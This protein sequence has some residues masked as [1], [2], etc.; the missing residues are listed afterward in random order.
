ML[1]IRPAELTLVSESGSKEYDG[2]PLER[3]QVKVEGSIITTNDRAQISNIKATGSATG[4]TTDPVPNTI[5]YETSEDFIPENYLIKKT[6]GTLT[7]TKNTKTEIVFTADS[8]QKKYDGTPLTASGVTV[9]GLSN[10]FTAQ[11]EAGGSITNV[12]QTEEGNN[13]VVSARI[14]DKEGKDVTGWFT[15]ITKNAGTLTITAREITLTSADATKVYDGTPLEKK[16][17]TVGGTD[18]LVKTHQ[19]EYTF[20][21]SQTYV[22]SS[23]NTFTYLIKDKEGNVIPTS[24]T[25]VSRKSLLRKSGQVEPEGNYRIKVVYGTLTV[26]DDVEPEKVVTKTHEEKV[27]QLGEQIVF[28]IRVTNIYD[29]A[30]TVTLTEQDGVVFTGPDTFTDVQPGATV[31]TSACH[32]VNEDDLKEGTYTNTVKAEFKEVKKTWEGTDEEDQF[33][34]LTLAK[35]VT[36]APADETAYMNGETIRYQITV[37]NDGTA[38]LYSLKIADILTGDEWNNIQS[39]D[40][41]EELTF[42]T[43]YKVTDH[44]AENGFV[45]NQAVGNA[46]D[47][48]GNF[49]EPQPVSVRVPVQKAKPSLYLEKT[50]DKDKAVELG[51]TIH[52]TIRV[53]NNGNTAVSDIVVTDEMTGDSWNAGTL[54]PGEGKIFH[55]EYVVTEKDIL[56]G[57]VKN[58]ALADGKDPN[59]DKPDVTPGE[60]EDKTV[61]ENSHLTVTKK[62]V[63]SPKNRSGYTL[64]ETIRYWIEAVNDGNLT[65]TEVEVTDPLTGETWKVEKLAPGEKQ[66]FE[67]K[68]T[69]TEKDQSAGRVVNE[70]TAKGKTP[71][72]TELI[73]VP[74]KTSDPVLT[75]AAAAV[76]VSNTVQTGD[77]TQTGAYLAMLFVAAAG[78]GILAKKKKKERRK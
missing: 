31:T 46:Q 58:V 77:P 23:S 32:V 65:L 62:T 67:T 2:T 57:S 26:T 10:E 27:Y 35:E 40:P 73:V 53:V 49:V 56:A 66:I 18:G 68:Y 72:S 14:L 24:E 44:D 50:S 54:K 33:A 5:T 37:T 25:K 9:T 36:N 12:S 63:S 74:G 51:E 76:T 20:T 34:H 3:P 75:K 8:A 45:T 55:T 38:E 28:E 48:N 69:V 22:G 4:V 30:Q 71:G 43:S 6:V 64:G 61:P 29:T 7:V 78:I 1:E 59:G 60:K 52:Y 70:A 15:N 21:G 39:L 13:P 11:A 17:V 41:G 19:I 42:D 47:A 16:E